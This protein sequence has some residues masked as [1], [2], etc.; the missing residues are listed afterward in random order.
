MVP[1]ILVFKDLEK[2][3]IFMIVVLVKQIEKK[4]C[5]HKLPP[6]VPKDAARSMDLGKRAYGPKLY[7]LF[8]EKAKTFVFELSGWGLALESFWTSRT[9]LSVFCLGFLICTLPP[10]V[11]NKSS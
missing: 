2:V 7:F 1:G 9:K 10:R 4:I 3:W 8:K 5:P 11:G 6:T